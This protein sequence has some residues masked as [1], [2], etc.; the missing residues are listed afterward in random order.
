MSNPHPLDPPP[1]A[2]VG[3]QNTYALSDWIADAESVKQEVLAKLYERLA[4]QM[5]IP[6]GIV[7][8]G[9]LYTG[10]DD[11]RVLVRMRVPTA[12]LLLDFN[13]HMEEDK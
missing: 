9:Y 8:G 7:E 1:S 11:S 5:R 10:G 12:P 4:V 3:V 2:L 13:E 6:V